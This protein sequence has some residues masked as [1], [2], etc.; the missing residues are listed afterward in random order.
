MI[1]LRHR[2]HSGRLHFS[3]EQKKENQKQLIKCKAFEASFG[4]R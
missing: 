4:I 3:F 2:S 1:N